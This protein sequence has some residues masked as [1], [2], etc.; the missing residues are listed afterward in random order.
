MYHKTG[1]L[2]SLRQNVHQILL[3]TTISI[4]IDTDRTYTEESTMTRVN[5]KKGEK[6]KEIAEYIK[7]EEINS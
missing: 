5:Q 4:L 7:L 1:D 2:L 3:E 6:E